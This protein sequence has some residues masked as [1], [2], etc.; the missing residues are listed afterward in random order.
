MFS[1]KVRV[2]TGTIAST[3]PI[4]YKV[5][6]FLQTQVP[7]IM[8]QRG[9]FI[10][11]SAAWVVDSAIPDVK[12]HFYFPHGP[13]GVKSPLID[14]SMYVSPRPARSGQNYVVAR[15]NSVGDTP[16]D[17]IFQEVKLFGVLRKHK[18]AKERVL[19]SSLKTLKRSDD[20][21]Y[22]STGVTMPNIDYILRG[23]NILYGNPVVNPLSGTDPG[24]PKAVWFNSPQMK[25]VAPSRTWIPCRPLSA[26]T[27]T[28]AFGAHFKANVDVQNKNEELAT[29]SYSYVKSEAICSFYKG[30]LFLDL[31][32]R[33]TPQI[34]ATLK[35]CNADPSDEN[36]ESF[37]D[38]FGTHF[39]SEVVMG[40]K[41]GSESKMTTE[42]YESLKEQGLNVG[43]A[44]GYSGMFS[45]GYTQETDQ[46]TQERQK[47][48]SARESQISYTY[49]SQMPANGDANTWASETSDSPM[50]ISLELTSIAEVLTDNFAADLVDIDY[51]T[52]RPKLVDF[53]TRYCSK[54]VDVGKAKD[55][56]PPTEFATDGPGLLP[57]MD[58]GP[59]NIHI[60]MVNEN[61]MAIVSGK[62]TSEWTL[63][64]VKDKTET[65]S[66]VIEHGNVILDVTV[67]P[68]RNRFGVV[69]S[70]FYSWAYIQMYDVSEDGKTVTEGLQLKLQDYKVGP[71]DV[72]FNC[73]S[74]Y[75]AVN[76][77]LLVKKAWPS[78][79]ELIKI[80]DI[81]FANAQGVTPEVFINAGCEDCNPQA[82][83]HLGGFLYAI[84]TYTQRSVK[85]IEVLSGSEYKV[86][87]SIPYESKLMMSD[88]YKDDTNTLV[89]TLANKNSFGDTRIV[90]YRWDPDTKTMT[91]AANL[92]TEKKLLDIP[93]VGSIVIQGKYIYFGESI[94]GRAY[95]YVF[96]YE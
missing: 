78:N 42:S 41:Y 21:T 54:L 35:K 86:L 80:E 25:V 74:Y 28:G 57:W 48:E 71:E 12:P 79:F 66:K 49:G 89:M 26:L 14:S 32:P 1:E 52:L 36:F 44:A 65:Y 17:S 7:A 37:V 60:D 90:A 5:L 30:T 68:N 13:K 87:Q 72:S 82:G 77:F 70:D 24:Y 84:S 34:L 23:Y 73:L 92:L 63:K 27:E 15:Q 22:M 88:I 11:F 67:C 85:V 55:C 59:N 31:P 93:D 94:T 20:A 50:P 4:P 45:A 69:H 39:T 38:Y 29:A 64:I 40:S 95:Q 47:F 9:Q 2:K 61:M 16:E 51:K 43:T 75:H 6:R 96:T 83:L 81:C 19:M 10:G 58:T 53:L 76:G 8:A 56:M 62:S 46:Q 18:N 91:F 3:T 33:L